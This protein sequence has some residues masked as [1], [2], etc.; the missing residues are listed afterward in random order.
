MRYNIIA[1]K[2]QKACR[3]AATPKDFDYKVIAIIWK[4]GRLLYVYGQKFYQ[5]DKKYCPTN[6]EI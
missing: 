5:K 4:L 3:K 1:G 6:S 2:K